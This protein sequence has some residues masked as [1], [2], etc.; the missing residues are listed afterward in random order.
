MFPYCSSIILVSLSG[1]K[2]WQFRSSYS[3]W[4]IPSSPMILTH[5]GMQEREREREKIGILEIKTGRER[6]HIWC[7]SQ[8]FSIGVS[9]LTDHN[10]KNKMQTNNYNFILLQFIRMFSDPSLK[11]S[12]DN[13]KGTNTRICFSIL[14]ISFIICCYSLCN[15]IKNGRTRMKYLFQS[16]KQF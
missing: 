7:M 9:I 13:F 6:D 2:S 4:K 5:N 15:K 14:I 11:V 8:F 12:D 10:P 1:R 16:L 3:S